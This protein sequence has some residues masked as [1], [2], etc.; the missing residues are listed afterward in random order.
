MVN[1]VTGQ[2]V[3]TLAE[4]L[5]RGQLVADRWLAQKEAG[6]GADAAEGETHK[7]HPDGIGVGAGAV[8]TTQTVELLLGFDPAEPVQA[9][10]GKPIG[11]EVSVPD[12]QHLT[13]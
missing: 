4:V 5:S 6:Y 10:I 13:V 9:A 3:G 2:S 11:T 8:A 1:I 12:L 7:T